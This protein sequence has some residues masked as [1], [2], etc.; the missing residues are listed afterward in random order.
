MFVYVNVCVMGMG[1]CG[2]VRVLA[3]AQ[4]LVCMN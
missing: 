1:V 4:V 3:R 2:C